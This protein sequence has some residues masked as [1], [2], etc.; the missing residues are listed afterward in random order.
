MNILKG[1][2]NWLTYPWNIYPKGKN[3][4]NSCFRGS[5]NYSQESDGT[6]L[7]SIEDWEETIDT[8]SGDLV[9]C[10]GEFDDLRNRRF[11]R[12]SA[13]LIV[14]RLENGKDPNLDFPNL[15]S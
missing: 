2:W 12:E 1:L 5:R 6:Y 11:T 4:K 13:R 10:W 7:Y 9:D 14:Q 8:S 15:H 3:R